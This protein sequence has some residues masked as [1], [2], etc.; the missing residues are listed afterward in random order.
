MGRKSSSKLQHASSPQP[1][2]EPPKRNTPLIIGVIAIVAIAVGV[3]AFRNGP[4]ADVAS[5]AT[6]TTTN[7]DAATTPGTNPP[8]VQVSAESQQRADAVAAFGPRPPSNLPPIPFRGYAPPRPPEVVAAAYQFAAEH[9]EILSYVPCFC[10]CERS[11]HGGNHDC[12]V[13]SRTATGDVLEWDEHGIECAVCIDVAT[14]S[15]QMYTSG[16]SAKDI[17]AAI[18]KEYSSKFPSMTPTAHPP[19]HGSH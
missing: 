12:F 13:K 17:R 1:P 10:G 7:S 18:E 6:P 2:A 11:G 9:P 19:A 14:R 4:P 8:V 3:L 15:R 5:E 16:A